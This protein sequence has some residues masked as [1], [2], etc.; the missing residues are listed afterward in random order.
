VLFTFGLLAVYRVGAWIPSPGI[1]PAALE[2]FFSQQG[3]SFLGLVNLFSGGNLRK[4]T[5]FA[6]GIMPY[7]S[8]SIILQLLTVIWPYLEKLSKEGEMGRKKITTYTRWGT[9]VLS[10]IQGSGIAVWAQNAV[11]QA[12]PHPGA[13]F[14]FMTVVTLTTGTAFIMWLGEQITER[15]IDNRISRM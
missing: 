14:I 10:I 1:N 2:E 11:P 3:G 13:W 8:S 5:I 4:L 15:G 12:V 6:L 9:I 7:I